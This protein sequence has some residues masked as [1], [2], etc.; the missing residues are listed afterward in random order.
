MNGLLGSLSVER[1]S[2]PNLQELAFQQQFHR[3]FARSASAA[4]AISLA[5]AG[6]PSLHLDNQ[7]DGAGERSFCGLSV[8]I[9]DA[10]GWAVLC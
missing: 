6:I 10:L 3:G 7:L 9:P 4:D 5:A 1:T 2:T 8:L